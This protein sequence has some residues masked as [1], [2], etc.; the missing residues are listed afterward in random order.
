MTFLNI[1][2]VSSNI[3]DAISRA[4][5][6]S[7]VLGC[8]FFSNSGG[9]AGSFFLGICF[10]AGSLGI[11]RGNKM[12]FSMRL[13]TPDRQSCTQLVASVNGVTMII[14]FLPSVT[15]EEEAM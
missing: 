1:F 4:M 2:F 9:L 14:L 8:D 12:D 13:F 15:R 6:A 10:S 5:A 3:L 11:L 7:S